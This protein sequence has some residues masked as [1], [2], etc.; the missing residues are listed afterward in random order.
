MD[1]AYHFHLVG[2]AA[3]TFYTRAPPNPDAGYPAYIPYTIISIAVVVCVVSNAVLANTA[4]LSRNRMA[5]SIHNKR[6]LWKLTAEKDA[7]QRSEALK[8]QFISVA[9]HE[10]TVL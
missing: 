5:E 2:M 7:A 1:Y 8:Q 10:V 9:S 3:A 6:K 4:I